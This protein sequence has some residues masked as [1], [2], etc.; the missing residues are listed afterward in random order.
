[1]PRSKTRIIKHHVSAN[2]LAKE[3][4]GIQAVSRKETRGGE[5]RGD[6]EMLNKKK[7]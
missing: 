2:G 6:E 3:K 5:K 1:M 7:G 4:R